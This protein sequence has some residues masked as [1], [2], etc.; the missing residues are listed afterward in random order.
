VLPLAL[1][2]APE[3]ARA[4][5]EAALLREVAAH[6]GRL[7]TGFVSTPYL[8][9]ILSDLDPEAC[10]RLVT[11]REFPSWY[12]MTVAS[13]NDLL[14]ETWAGGMAVMPSLGGS[15]ARWC[16]RSLGGIRPDPAAPG[17][18]KIIIRPTFV[19]A[20]KWVES[21]H[22]SPYGRINSNWRRDGDQLKMDVTI[23]CNTTATVVV[24]G[25]TAITV[26][27]KPQVQGEF[28]LSAGRWEILLKHAKE[29]K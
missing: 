2:L 29:L 25:F 8:L 7:S 24:P 14:K 13:H 15:V 26:N 20:L 10:W 23:P 1:H 17:F 18:K 28:S 9:D 12:S 22:E 5:V 16:Y 27:G 19:T 21:H 11:S 3:A 6:K 4:K